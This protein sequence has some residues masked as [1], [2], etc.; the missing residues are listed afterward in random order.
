M[1]PPNNIQTSIE[2]DF[3]LA[4]G[5]STIF[6][7]GLCTFLDPIWG[8]NDDPMFSMIA[9]GYGL[10]IQ[11]SPIFPFYQHPSM[12]WGYLVRAIPFI[13]GMPGHSIALYLSITAVGAAIIFGIRRQGFG[14][15]LAII[16]VLLILTRPIIS[17]IFTMTAGFLVVGAIV[18]VWIY[19]R[20]PRVG[21]IVFGCVLTFLGYLLREQM[22]FFVALIA[23]PLLPWK[24]LIGDRSAVVALVVLL[25]FIGG[26][27]GV[28][29]LSRS[30]ETWQE[31][32]RFQKV[33]TRL[34][35]FRGIQTLK[36]K[37][38][39]LAKHGI[40]NNDI[41]LFERTYFWHDK[42]S[43]MAIISAG[44]SLNKNQSFTFKSDFRQVLLALTIVGIFVFC[45]LPSLRVGLAWLI[46]IT[47]STVLEAL[48]RAPP[49]RL[50]YPVLSLL[51]LAP[52]FHVGRFSLFRYKGFKTVFVLGL[53]FPTIL[54]ART[55]INFSQE[56]QNEA[57]I[58]RVAYAQLPNRGTF[59]GAGARY[60]QIFPVFGIPKNTVERQFTSLSMPAI[61]D[62]IPQLTTNFQTAFRSPEGA[63]MFTGF[64][65]EVDFSLMSIFCAERFDGGMT[66]LRKW[67]LPGIDARQIRCDPF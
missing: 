49:M 61:R 22:F 50:I 4:L 46:L 56:K 35:D 53:A 21:V 40:S 15:P 38:E 51:I 7:I 20:E 60:R 9:H 3:F 1:K 54:M 16:M 29:Y 27:K 12:L 5:L 8:D 43:T 19:E 34:I 47:L 18:C 37:P 25:M 23:L 52:L 62:G 24:R 59:A 31:L 55:T 67:E 64:S 65:D 26:A 32:D 10:S 41:Q 58:V 42:E 36:T 33:S 17:P 2:R 66:T 14:W 39:L 48:G 11:G 45:F 6:V 30:G 63:I 28:Q 44:K 13:D 57:N